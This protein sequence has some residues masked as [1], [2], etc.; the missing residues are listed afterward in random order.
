MSMID[1]QKGHGLMLKLRHQ[2][3][4]EELQAQISA[5]MADTQELTA[6][7]TAWEAELQV[8]CPRFSSSLHAPLMF[9]PG[10]VRADSAYDNSRPRPSLLLNTGSACTCSLWVRQCAAIV[11]CIKGMQL[12][13]KMKGPPFTPALSRVTASWLLPP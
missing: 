8:M 13:I 2:D 5:A 9:L 4:I 11:S 10:R 6:R 12:I 3:K 1:K 7:N